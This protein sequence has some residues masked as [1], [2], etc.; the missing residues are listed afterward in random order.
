MSQYTTETHSEVLYRR[1]Y[2]SHCDNIY[3][4]RNNFNIFT[5]EL[6]SE[7]PQYSNALNESFNKAALEKEKRP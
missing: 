5:L 3:N 4:K 2:S 1:K 7:G 6:L